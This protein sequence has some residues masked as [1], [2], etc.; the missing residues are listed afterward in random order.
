MK[1]I[2]FELRFVRA[3][4]CNFRTGAQRDARRLRGRS[5]G[6]GEV[7]MLMSVFSSLGA[8][9]EFITVVLVSFFSDGGFTTVVLLSFF[10]AGGVT[11]VSFC[12]HAA[13]KPKIAKA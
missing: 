6:L 8:G 1:R 7:L 3:G 11:V 9:E 13:S 12:S 4:R 10:S 5:Y 2:K